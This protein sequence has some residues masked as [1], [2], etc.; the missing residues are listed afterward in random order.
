MTADLVR[1][2]TQT[3]LT[4][5]VYGQSRYIGG[6]AVRLF[7]ADGLQFCAR[8]A[9][10]G[11]EVDPSSDPGA[12]HTE[13]V[14]HAE[15]TGGRGRWRRATAAIVATATASQAAEQQGRDHTDAH[16]APP[17]TDRIATVQVRAACLA[18]P[19]L[20]THIYFVIQHKKPLAFSDSVIRQFFDL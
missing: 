19:S 9:N 17:L 7:T 15:L 6:T 4:G 14:H 11:G 8:A 3:T 16:D 18:T 20:A 13:T 2:L 1:E 5:D 10:I 12:H